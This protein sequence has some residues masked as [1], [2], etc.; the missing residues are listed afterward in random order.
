[1]YGH[2]VISNKVVYINVFL[3][4]VYLERNSPILHIIFENVL[5]ITATTICQK[6]SYLLR[7]SGCVQRN[8]SPIFA[9]QF[10]NEFIILDIYAIKR[11]GQWRDQRAMRVEWFARV[12]QLKCSPWLANNPSE[13]ERASWVGKRKS[14]YSGWVSECGEQL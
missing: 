4:L 2:L 13:R 6:L 10:R 12:A 9:H 14:P 1:M 11:C 3:C 7:T 8:R 5:L